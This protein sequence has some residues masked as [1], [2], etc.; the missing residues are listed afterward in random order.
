MGFC[1]MRVHRQLLPAALAAD[2]DSLRVTSASIQ[3]KV[4]RC[5]Q[6][7]PHN[8]Q[9]VDVAVEVSITPDRID[10][11]DGMAVITMT[12]KGVSCQIFTCILSPEVLASVLNTVGKPCPLM[13]F[14]A[15]GWNRRRDV[16]CGGARISSDS[17]SARMLMKMVMRGSKIIIEG[18]TKSFMMFVS[19]PIRCFD[20]RRGRACSLL[21][22]GGMAMPCRPALVGGVGADIRLGEVAGGRG[23][24]TLVEPNSNVFRRRRLRLAG[25]GIS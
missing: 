16:E 23:R 4:A 15:W 13:P 7:A 12:T 22:R 18:F 6:T 3:G 10:L 17:G 19:L 8:S 11:H 1:G 21:V 5:R 25:A 14:I 9:G 2:I 24:K 20:P